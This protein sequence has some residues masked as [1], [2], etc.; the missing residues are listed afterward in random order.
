MDFCQQVPNFKNIKNL[1]PFGHD[2]FEK[3]WGELARKMLESNNVPP[4]Q[5]IHI[6]PIQPIPIPPI[7]YIPIQ[8]MAPLLHPISFNQNPLHEKVNKARSILKK[9]KEIF[10]ERQEKHLE[11]K[12]MFIESE[13]KSLEDLFSVL[14]VHNSKQLK[15]EFVPRTSLIE[16]YAE[17]SK[18]NPC[19]FLIF[20][21]HVIIKDD[22][23]ESIKANFIQKNDQVFD[24]DNEVM[25]Q[26]QYIDN[27]LIQNEMIDEFRF[28]FNCLQTNWICV[29]YIKNK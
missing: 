20:V 15:Q 13:L 28:L 8:Q 14:K 11:Q 5:P 18:M 16:M 10:K 26:I 21:Q 19:K 29:K 7:Q 24:G 27:K 17:D 25:I 1:P 12:P 23:I 6:P 9:M 3:V 22:I 2:N 4:I